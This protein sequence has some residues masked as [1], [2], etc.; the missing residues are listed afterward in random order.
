MHTEEDSRKTD[1]CPPPVNYPILVATVFGPDS[2]L[3][4]AWIDMDRCVQITAHEPTFV[5]GG[6][7][8][9]DIEGNENVICSGKIWFGVLMEEDGKRLIKTNVPMN[10]ASTYLFWDKENVPLNEDLGKTIGE[11]I[12]RACQRHKD[13]FF[14]VVL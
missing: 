10:E 1:R 4:E 13:K 12:V 9:E 2:R 8:A 5:K 11:R 14:E 7:S 3:Y 6:K